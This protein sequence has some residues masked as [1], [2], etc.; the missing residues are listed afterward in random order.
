MTQPAGWYDDPQDPSQLR[1]WDGVVWSTHVSPKISPTVEQST[2]GM[3]Y[4]VIPAGERPHSAGSQGAQGP[5][6]LQDGYPTPQQGQTGGQWPAYGQGPG[7]L[8]QPG[9]QGPGWQTPKA[10]TP[11]GVVLSGWWKRV[12]ARFLDGIIAAIVSLPLTYAPLAH[13]I[14]LFGDFFQKIFADAQA[15]ITTTAQ[16]PA[17]L[18]SLLLQ[19][20]VVQLVVYIVYEVAFLTWRGAT[21]GKMVVGISVRLRDKAGP[22]PFVDAVKRTAVKEAGTA[23]GLVPVVGA[24]GSLFTLLDGLW[25]LWD[26]KKQAIH[27]KAASTNV[28]VGPQPRRG[29]GAPHV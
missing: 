11:D 15:G 29:A 12:L 5:A 16:P 21:P 17:E 20:S 18:N 23:F 6:T 8:G 25:P 10:T 22:L 24:L 28:V 4:G 9:Q 19:V 13:A 14:T 2:I 1:Y 3:P 27:D 7:Q 26:D